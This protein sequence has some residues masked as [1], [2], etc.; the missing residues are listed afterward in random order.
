MDQYSK[1]VG[2]VGMEFKVVE[3]NKTVYGK[4]LTANCIANELMDSLSEEEFEVMHALLGDDCFNFKTFTAKAVCQDSD[5]FNPEVGMNIAEAKMRAK[6]HAWRQGIYK[7][8]VQ[9]LSKLAT[10]L[11]ELDDR[12]YRKETAIRHDFNEYYCGGEKA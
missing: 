6:D 5:N 12:H 3:E 11:E 10:K 2:N 9:K 7:N 4:M 1:I 8:A